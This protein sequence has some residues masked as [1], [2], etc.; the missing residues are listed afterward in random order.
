M[1][2]NNSDLTLCEIW[3]SK[4]ESVRLCCSALWIILLKKSEVFLAQLHSI[5][6]NIKLN[7]YHIQSKLVKF[8]LFTRQKV[9]I[10]VEQET[11]K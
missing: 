2:L 5:N 1:K 10:K 7:L 11:S 4:C 3:R 8:V 9:E 6:I